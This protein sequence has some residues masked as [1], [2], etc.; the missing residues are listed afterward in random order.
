MDSSAP[1]PPFSSLRVVGDMNGRPFISYLSPK[2]AFND[3]SPTFFSLLSEQQLAEIRPTSIEVC[4]GGYGRLRSQRVNEYKGS[5]LAAK[6]FLNGKL[7][8]TPLIFWELI[9]F[10]RFLLSKHL[11]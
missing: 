9:K 3:H 6:T 5:E 1:F 2:G 10:H 4:M 8:I 7:P 11:Y